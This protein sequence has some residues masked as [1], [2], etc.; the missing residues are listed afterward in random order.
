MAVF[1]SANKSPLVSVDLIGEKN[2]VILELLTNN[3][4]QTWNMS[5]LIFNLLEKIVILYTC[6]YICAVVVDVLE[7]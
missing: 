6:M 5:C 3:Y 7:E 2:Q 4:D 1:L